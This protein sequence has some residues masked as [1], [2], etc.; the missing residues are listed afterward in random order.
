MFKRLIWRSNGLKGK[1]NGDTAGNCRCES[2]KISG[3]ET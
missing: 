1:V 2:E 3:D